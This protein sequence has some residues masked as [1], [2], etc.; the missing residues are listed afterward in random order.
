MKCSRAHI[1]SRAQVGLRVRARVIVRVIVRV[2][3]EPKEIT[4]CL[5]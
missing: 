2:K 4:T 5:K 1:A 3:E